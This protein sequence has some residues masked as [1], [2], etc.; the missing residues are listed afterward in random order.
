MQNKRTS[1]Q[2]AIPSA[3]ISKPASILTILLN[4]TTEMS[5]LDRLKATP[6]MSILSTN[7]EV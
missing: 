1:E 2:I 6:G 7:D 5:R 4:F 3:I